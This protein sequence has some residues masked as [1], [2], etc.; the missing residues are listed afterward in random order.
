[1]GWNSKE[2]NKEYREKNKEHLKE[3]K[4]E[5]YLKNKEELKEKNSINYKKWCKTPYGRASGLVKSYNH[6]DK[7]Y[8]RGKGDITAKWIVENIF[9][10]PCIHCGETDWTKLGCNRIDESRPH[11]KDNVEPCCKECNIKLHSMDI[12]KQVLQYTLDGELVKIWENGYKAAEEVN[13]YYS[14]IHRCCNGKQKY[15][16]GFIWRYA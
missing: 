13:G 1:M 6:N 16:K 15:H 9:T 3:Y 5:Y 10:R 8:G 12:S 2:Y 11:T 7:K 4:R 14:N